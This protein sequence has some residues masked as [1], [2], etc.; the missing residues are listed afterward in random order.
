MKLKDELILIYTNTVR[1]QFLLT[2]LVH[3]LGMTYEQ[4]LD[5][6]Q[7]LVNNGYLEYSESQFPSLSKHGMEYLNTVGLSEADIYSLYNESTVLLNITHPSKFVYIPL[8]F[9]MKFKGYK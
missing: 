5:I 7:A 9:N 6:I 1:E 3:M 4:V 2:E 8:N